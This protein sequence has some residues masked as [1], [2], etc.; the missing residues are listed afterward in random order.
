MCQTQVLLPHARDG[1]HGLIWGMARTSDCGGVLE[2]QSTILVTRSYYPECH[3]LVA[4][5]KGMLISWPSYS[6]AFSQHSHFTHGAKA[7][8]IYFRYYTCTYKW[9]KIHLRYEPI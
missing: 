4:S 2:L 3:R 1:D 5:T 8:A 9:V 7:G 6:L